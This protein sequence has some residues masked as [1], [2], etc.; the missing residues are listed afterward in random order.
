MSSFVPNP[1]PRSYHFSAFRNKSAFY[2]GG[3]TWDAVERK[4]V[5]ADLECLSELD[6]VANKCN[7]HLLKGQHPPGVDDGACAVVGDCLFLYGGKDK[8]RKPTGSLF[9]LNLS[10]KSWRERSRSG[11]CGPKKKY[12]C[13]M[14]AYNSELIIYG[15]V[16]RDGSST[17]ELHTF[18]LNSGKWYS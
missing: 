3:K 11:T 1:S 13:G 16:T 4:Y 7:K 9:E 15:G 5:P 2:W 17:N 18:D 10:T 14:V 12:S 8:E 6:V